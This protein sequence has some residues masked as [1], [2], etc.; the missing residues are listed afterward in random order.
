MTCRHLSL[1]RAFALMA[2][3]LAAT[4]ALT[5]RAGSAAAQDHPY[6]TLVMGTVIG[7]TGG[8]VSVYSGATICTTIA[9][10]AIMS[11]GTYQIVVN[12]GAGIGTL[13]VDGTPTTATFPLIPGT[14]SSNVN[15]TI[16]GSPSS[17]PTTQNAT[18]TTVP[19]STSTTAAGTT[20]TA[21]GTRTADTPAAP[22]KG[23]TGDALLLTRLFRSPLPRAE[24]DKTG[25]RLGENLE[26]A[27]NHHLRR[28]RD[29]RAQ[30][31]GSIRVSTDAMARKASPLWRRGASAARKG[32]P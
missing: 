28:G 31:R 4:V 21:A 8:T 1:A 18:A 19:G 10:G 11:D 25:A 3:L 12:C 5:L 32:S 13:Y 15:A 24:F 22:G 17:M 23:A 27:A 20:T 26:L 14:V 2:I 30:P 9:G 16:G 6:D 29:S 7:A